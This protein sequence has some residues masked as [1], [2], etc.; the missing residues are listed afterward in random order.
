MT[1]PTRACGNPD[2]S[3]STAI[4]DTTLT[5]GRGT[6]DAHGFWEIPCGPCA[7]AAEQE[8]PSCGPCWPFAEQESTATENSDKKLTVK[9]AEALINPR[10]RS[11]RLY[12]RAQDP[13]ANNPKET[14]LFRLYTGGAQALLG[15]AR[16]TTLQKLL[17]SE[18]GYKH[19]HWTAVGGNASI[20]WLPE[21]A[22]YV[23]PTPEMP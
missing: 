15:G 17:K 16:W 11:G 9:V 14:A 2:C 20:D 5:Y 3:V 18:P 22:E 7:R 23:E 8:R 1:T 12:F 13:G 21:E 19:P 4:D 6:L 10:V